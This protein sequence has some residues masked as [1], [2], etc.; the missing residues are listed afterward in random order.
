MRGFSFWIV[1][2][3]LSIV[4]IGAAFIYKLST[5]FTAKSK[6]SEKEL[7][8]FFKREPEM[9]KNYILEQSV[10]TKMEF[11]GEVPAEIKSL[12]EVSEVSARYRIIKRGNFFERYGEIEKP[13][14]KST[15]ELSDIDNSVYYSCENVNGTWSCKKT[16]YIDIGPVELDKL[17]IIALKSLKE[18]IGG[19]DVEMYGSRKK[20]FS[21]T[22]VCVNINAKEL[23]DQVY[24]K[25]IG[26]G[27][28]N[29]DKLSGYYC[30][31][32]KSKLPLESKFELEM[33]FQIEDKKGRVR[34]IG[35]VEALRFEE[36]QASLEEF[37]SAIKGKTLYVCE[38]CEYSTLDKAL[39][40]A[41]IGDKIVLNTM[42]EYKAKDFEAFGLTIDCGGSSLKLDK[43][44]GRFI[45]FRNCKLEGLDSNGGVGIFGDD[46]E[47]LNSII[48]GSIFV[49]KGKIRVANSQV[50]GGI[51]V[52]SFH[53]ENDYQLEIINN[54]ILNSE[55]SIGSSEN[56]KIEGNTFTDSNV[57]VY[58]CKD[59]KLINNKLVSS[60]SGFMAS[61]I[62]ISNSENIYINR[63]E[64]NAKEEESTSGSIKIIRKGI[65][66]TISNSTKVYVND[67]KIIGYV[68]GI[69]LDKYSKEIDIKGNSFI[70][71]SDNIK[72]S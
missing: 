66:I 70:D 62:G 44:R 21:Q 9:L 13:V 68:I 46:I 12:K 10:S 8:D 43:I 52:D 33:S 69:E 26:N 28:I 67:N 2:I 14:K 56:A 40:K 6:I 17:G 22:C 65:G 61:G 45:T 3:A 58:M 60:S 39:E 27:D 50:H 54:Q 31:E 49:F 57:C 23:L 7:E 41:T 19:K 5:N 29:V 51:D 48:N 32:E 24:K 20:C 37:K 36:T 71:N 16:W 11:S 53:G 25:T 30:M 42:G 35:S 59:V 15:L 63:N 72:Y 18:S 55:I 64:L 34:L 1:L 38:N 47:I 4:A